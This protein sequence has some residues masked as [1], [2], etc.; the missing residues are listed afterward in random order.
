MDDGIDNIIN[1]KDSAVALAESFDNEPMEINQV[2]FTRGTR[3]KLVEL[4]HF[5]ARTK[6]ELA[7]FQNRMASFENRIK[8]L[9]KN[10][11]SSFYVEVKPLT[12]E[13]AEQYFGHKRGESYKPATL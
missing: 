13:Q 5:F 2:Q 10:I 11:D 9:T 1:H 8:E 4:Q 7:Y 6:E 3:E 12:P